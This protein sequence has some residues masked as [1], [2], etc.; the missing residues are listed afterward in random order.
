MT[1][2]PEKSFQVFL[3]TPGPWNITKILSFDPFT[4]HDMKTIS[5]WRVVIVMI[6]AHADL[7]YNW[8][9]NIHIKQEVFLYLLLLQWY[10]SQN[11]QWEI[12]FGRN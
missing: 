2:V 8:K 12:L 4:R 11:I 10:S 6:D 5:T 7:E 1:L 9:K 3:A